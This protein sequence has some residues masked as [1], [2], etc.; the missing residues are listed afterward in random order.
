MTPETYALRCQEL[1]I[2]KSFTQ[3]EMPPGH[4]SYKESTYLRED[5][6]NHLGP[7]VNPYEPENLEHLN[8][9][10]T[11]NRSNCVKAFWESM[12]PEQREA[13]RYARRNNGKAHHSPKL[14]HK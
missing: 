12:T 14:K 13:A 2:D 11:A 8:P 9:K 7:R 6:H 3:R 5:G 10:H 4:E 1:G